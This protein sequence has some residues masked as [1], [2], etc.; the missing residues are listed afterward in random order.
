MKK[1]ADFF[2]LKWDDLNLSKA[3][4]LKKNVFQL[5]FSVFL[6]VCLIWVNNTVDSKAI[7]KYKD[8]FSRTQSVQILTARQALEDHFRDVISRISLLSDN[9]I[10]PLIKNNIKSKEN[11]NNIQNFIIRYPDIILIILQKEKIKKEI[12]NYGIL[13]PQ[14]K[15]ILKLGE[16][17]LQNF[18]VNYKEQAPVRT[19]KI[20]M[21]NRHPILPLM[22]DRNPDQ[23]REGIILVSLVDLLPYLERYV[24]PLRG[25]KYSVSYILDEQGN[26]IFNRGGD[27]LGLS[28][29]ENSGSFKSAIQS[30]PSGSTIY[31]P[32]GQRTRIIVNWDTIRI[33]NKRLTIVL[34]IPEKELAATIQEER[35]VRGLLFIFF[36]ISIAMMMIFFVNQKNKAE[37]RKREIR[38]QAIIDDQFEMVIRYTPDGTFTFANDAY[39]DFLKKDRSQILGH[40]LQNMISEE[41]LE[42]VRKTLALITTETPSGIRE[43]MYDRPEGK[44]YLSW[45]N[46]GIF[47]EQGELEEI[48]GV[49]RNITDRK[50]AEQ[51]L[52]NETRQMQKLHHIVQKLTL[53]HKEKD[54]FQGLL[55]SLVEEMGYFCAS[56]IT[57][58]EE[59]KKIFSVAGKKVEP[60]P[61][62]TEKAISSE[63]PYTAKRKDGLYQTSLPISF[64]G[65]NLGLINAV[66]KEAPNKTE[67]R[68]LSILTDHFSG[69]WEA[70]KLMKQVTRE[71]LID[72]L[73]GIWNR[74]Y[75]LQQLQGEENRLKR[76][77]SCASII[78]A[79]LGDFKHINDTY[80]HAEGDR[81]LKKVAQ[82][83]TESTRNC[84]MVARYGGDEF[85]LYLPE[86]SPE[87]ANNVMFRAIRK[88]YKQKFPSKIFVDYGVAGYPTDGDSLISIT[89][90]ADER[91]YKAKTS[92]K[93]ERQR[94][95]R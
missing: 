11:Q 62:I 93:E 74:R 94:K 14:K 92:R 70:A 48:Q 72:P 86:T 49:G 95:K 56:I 60:E 73:T 44:I 79:D 50:I 88:I 33:L 2:T 18:M 65:I 4:E 67:L 53:F 12:P 69:L 22:I 32:K 64:Q 23:V 29:S 3:P 46:R 27:T 58:R 85:L 6:F 28:S 91:M 15:Q 39:C 83:L 34:A 35:T 36:L 21:L 43:E 47:N 81:V 31:R 68:I 57:I 80:G 63:A 42:R 17:A 5:W 37:I 84:D 24:A 38:Y 75:I 76:N 19:G 25:N 7:K 82:G 10:M 26:S 87:Q 1:N 77:M 90:K 9:N 55:N 52:E 78:L 8:S 51:V 71:S 30:S 16:S 54:L 40:K 13:S 66:K 45:T 59:K 41:H 89:Q 61:F 20:T